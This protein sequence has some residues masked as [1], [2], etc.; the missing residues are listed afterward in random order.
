MKKVIQTF[1]GDNKPVEIDLLYSSLDKE[2]FV[3]A[4]V[5]HHLKPDATKLQGCDIFLRDE[6]K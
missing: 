5:I 1:L 3:H 6:T 4:V 2:V